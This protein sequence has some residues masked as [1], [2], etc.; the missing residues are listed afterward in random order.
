MFSPEFMRFLINYQK[1]DFTPET[2]KKVIY[3][4]K[5]NRGYKRLASVILTVTSR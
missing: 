2:T 1:A 5:P 4:N 3:F